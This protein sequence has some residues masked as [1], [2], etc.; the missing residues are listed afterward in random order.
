MS[1]KQGDDPYSDHGKSQPCEQ[2]EDAYDAD[3]HLS[4]ILKNGKQ[5]GL[6][7]HIFD[8]GNFPVGDKPDKISNSVCE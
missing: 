5:S 8:R 7:G 1:G 2:P 6:V 4:D 3:A